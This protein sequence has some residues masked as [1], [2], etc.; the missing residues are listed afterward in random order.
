MK[1]T[2]TSTLSQWERG[3][4][5]NPFR[6]E[7]ITDVQAAAKLL[8]P[9]MQTNFSSMS[10]IFHPSLA[11]P[12]E[13]EGRGI[14]K[15]VRKGEGIGIRSEGSPQGGRGQNRERRVGGSRPRTLV[16]L[17]TLS[18]LTTF[19]R[20]PLADLTI[21]IAP[22]GRLNNLLPT[23]SSRRGGLGRGDSVSLSL[24]PRGRDQSHLLLRGCFHQAPG[25]GIG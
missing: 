7:M 24:T 6:W 14:V 18:D 12:V 11:L 17:L 20:L 4:E 19:F 13:G 1:G 2:L 22:S 16:R 3:A 5:G 8:Q 21:F 9:L 15:G 23:P 10:A 25:C